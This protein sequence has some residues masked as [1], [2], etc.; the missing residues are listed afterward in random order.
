M[1]QADIIH[2]AGTQASLRDPWLSGLRATL[3]GAGHDFDR[4]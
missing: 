4:S 3:Y 2:R 1:S